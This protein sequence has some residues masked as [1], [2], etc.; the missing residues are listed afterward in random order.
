MRGDTSPRAWGSN[1]LCPPPA[2]GD[3]PQPPG[4]PHWWREADSPA[5][6]IAMGERGGGAEPGGMT[7]VDDAELP[8]SEQPLF[9]LICRSRGSSRTCQSTIQLLHRN[10][11]RF[12]GGL[13]FKA[14]RLLYQSTLVLKVIKKK[15]KLNPS[16]QMLV[17]GSRPGAKKVTRVVF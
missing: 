8:D 5:S 16:I 17:S 3:D 13:V 12:R 15:K 9:F 4:D 14:H 7:G 10:V 1:A 6:L 11:Q 2:K